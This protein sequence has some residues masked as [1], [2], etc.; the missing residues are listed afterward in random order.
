MAHHA[1]LKRWLRAMHK[2]SPWTRYGRERIVVGRGKEKS[3]NNKN[4]QATGHAVTEKCEE[5]T[6]VEA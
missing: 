3:G 1:P 4:R 5:T 6:A 2:S